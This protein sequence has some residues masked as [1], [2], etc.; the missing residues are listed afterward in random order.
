MPL[1]AAA[2]LHAFVHG[3]FRP[4]DYTLTRDLYQKVE[5]LFDRYGLRTETGRTALINGL[6]EDVL[7]AFGLPADHT[8]LHPVTKL[9]RR[10]F[11]YEALCVL[12]RVDWS[13]R[14]S[15]SEYWQIRDELNEQRHILEDFEARYD[16]LRSCMVQCLEPIYGACPSLLDTRDAKS[17]IAI[18]TDLIHSV[19]EPGSITETIIAALFSEEVEKAGLFSRHRQRLD[20]NL[21]AAS[22][23][24]PADPKGFNRAIKWPSKSDI[25]DSLELIGTYLGGTPIADFFLQKSNLSIPPRTRMEH[26]WII[27]PPGA[28]KSTLLQHLLMQDFERVARNE[29][30][31]IVIDSNRD[32]AKSIER[33]GRFAKG[34]DLDGRLI[35]ID[36]EDVEYPVA[37]N[38]FDTQT[39]DAEALSPR[40]R[41]VLY[42]AAVSMLSY[43]F[44]AL[45]GAEMTSRQN[46]L[47]TF[48]IELLLALPSPTL[49]TLIDI[50]QPDGLAKFAHHIPALSPDAQRFFDIKFS[51]KE[52]VQTKSQVVDRLFAIKRIRALSRIFSSPKTK[53]NL[54]DELSHAKVI[55][56]N[57]AKSVLQEDGVEVFTRF[58]LANILLAAEKRQLIPQSR[59][60]PTYLYIDECQDVIR[61]DE[62]L[63]V[64][65]DQARKLRLGCIL[66]HQR[67]GQMTPPVLNALL[68][69]TAIKFAA[70]LADPNLA[71]VARSM[72]TTPEV[73]QKQPPFHFAAHIRGTTETAIPL[74]VPHVDFSTME[75][76]TDDEHRVLRDTMRSR[77]AVYHSELADTHEP[78]HPP[79]T[80]IDEDPDNPTTKPSSEW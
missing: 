2:R 18:E 41:E 77:Y 28:G 30:S 11:D 39:S 76:M 62:R 75:Q 52:F 53:L 45:L 71:S 35:F 19:G 68:G 22:G 34:G 69:S 44:H 56:I 15:I 72:Q 31:V 17:G 70:N 73:L 67:L 24:N 1:H 79:E 46:T 16:V 4:R 6:A 20:R 51:S 37:I 80:A 48:T 13:E 78:D 40:D 58:F 26:H 25:K 38:I 65:L 7:E 74:K 32:L 63:P 50:M 8:Q 55:V 64:V 60:L 43:I 36:C 42:N 23:G 10:I 9:V 49:D 47:F 61:R 3:L 59:R 29:A 14:H 21:I 12:P 33:L 66:A 57:A 27:A 54:F 5:Q